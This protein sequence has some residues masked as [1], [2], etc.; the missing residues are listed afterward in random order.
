[1][2]TRTFAPEVGP[3]YHLVATNVQAGNTGVAVGRIKRFHR[4]CGSWGTQA[5]SPAKNET[6]RGDPYWLKSLSSPSR[7]GKG[8]HFLQVTTRQAMFSDA[9]QE[10][11]HKSPCKMSAQ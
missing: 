4:S 10:R 3:F 5:K 6:V 2:M 11:K 7:Q 1:M 9:T 8:Q